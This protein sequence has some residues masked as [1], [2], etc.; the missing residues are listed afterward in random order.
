MTSQQASALLRYRSG[1]FLRRLLLVPQAV[2]ARFRGSTERGFRF[3]TAEDS[4]FKP[5]PEQSE[6]QPPLRGGSRPSQADSLLVNGETHLH[7]Y[8][9]ALP[10]P[11]ALH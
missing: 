7:R 11:G 2:P 1:F 10:N 9:P 8:F 3:K 6:S 4:E 5:D